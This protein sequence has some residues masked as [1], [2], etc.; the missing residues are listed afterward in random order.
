[1]VSGNYAHLV[2]SKLKTTSLQKSQFQFLAKHLNAKRNDLSGVRPFSLLPSA[3]DP[4]ENRRSTNQAN[5]RSLA[6]AR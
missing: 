3:K 4:V 6:V 1:L 5:G 2:F